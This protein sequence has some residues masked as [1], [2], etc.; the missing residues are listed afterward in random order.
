MVGTALITTLAE[1]TELHPAELVTVKVYVP[2]ASPVIVL[3]V[4]VPV[5]AT[6]PGLLVNVHVPEDGNP[7]NATDPVGAAQ[8]GWVIAPTTGAAMVG[9]A[10]TT[11]FAENGDVHPA[12]FCTVNL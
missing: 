4:P 3:V 2:E 11:T 7:L 9:T 6:A 10:L 1:A 8:V 12:A 5:T